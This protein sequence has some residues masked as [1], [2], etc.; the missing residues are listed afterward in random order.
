V[1][2]PA[3]AT[4]IALSL[5]A[6]TG[7]DERTQRK[8]LDFTELGAAA[9]LDLVTTSGETPST[10]I[11]EVKGGGIGLIDHDR[12]GDLDV[13]VPNGASMAHPQAGPGSRLF[14]NLGALSFADATPASGIDF[15]RFAMGVAVGDA[16]GNGW[17]DLFVTCYGRNGLLYNESGRFEEG[18]K[19]SNEGHDAWSTAAAFGDLDRDGDLDLYVANYLDFDVQNPP[20]RSTFKGAPVFKGPR[21]LQAQNDALLENTGQGR[22]LEIGESSGCCAVDPAYGLGVVI[23]DFDADGLQDI[24]VGNDSTPNF[25]FR[26]LG[27]LTFEEIGLRSGLSANVDGSTQSTMG[28][29]IA[30]V[31]G[32][33]FPDI[34]TTNFSN[35][36]NTLHM[37]KGG[38]FFDDETRRFGLGMREFALVGWACGLYDF[39]LDGDEDLLFFNGHVYPN[40]SLEIMDSDYRQPPRLYERKGHAFYKVEASE[41]GAFL[42]RVHCDRGAA[43]G[44]LDGDGDIDVVVSELNG[45]LRLLRNDTT[46]EGWLIVELIPTSLGSRIE[47]EG[48][49]SR[50]TR[51]IHSGGSFLS[52]SA[53]YVHFGLPRGCQSVELRVTWPDGHVQ[54]MSRVMA[55]QHLRIRRH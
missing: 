22:F 27:R 31:S 37:N 41:A 9:G 1:N 38:R 40:A 10:E 39:D 53:P 30:D 21:G 44:D 48:G 3:R 52:S 7:C 47:V 34:F 32:N 45:P 50:Q 43:F 49:G 29:G 24:Y 35:D 28:I 11:L 18:G 6:T 23:L 8:G 36:T 54:R 19:R 33:G 25:L 17:D 13:F 14:E 46:A 55:D 2:R 42:D 20:A 16:D 15:R 5:A 4:C 26:N 12:D 51:W